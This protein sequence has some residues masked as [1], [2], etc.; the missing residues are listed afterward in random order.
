MN[1]QD[2]RQVLARRLRALREV[3]WPG[4]KVNQ[5]QLAEALGGDG[6]R[7]VSVPLISSWES[8]TN[9]KVPPAARLQDIATFF[10]SPRSFDGRV[11]RLL[12]PDEMTAQERAAREEL[13]Q[14]LTRLRSE[15]LNAPAPSRPRSTVPA[16]GVVSP[17]ARAGPYRFK[18]RETITIV[19]AQ[20]PNEMLDERM[21]YTDPPG[22][23]LH[24]L[25]PVHG[26]RRAPGIVRARAGGQ[27]HEPGPVPG[28][29]SAWVRRVFGSSVP[30]GRCGLE[31]GD[32]LGPRPP[33][34]TCKAGQRV[35]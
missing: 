21:P 11:G 3:H 10:A 5:A 6:N 9:P 7:S 1:D 16:V 18:D 20:L 31:S 29:R 27:P 2:P 19:C 22:S 30:A 25:V 35:G 24:R 14:E 28:R 26:S 12:G 8:Q 13:L 15:A 32:Q 23:R 33:A 4:Q 34:A 17:A